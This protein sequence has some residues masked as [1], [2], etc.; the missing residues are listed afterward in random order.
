[1][2]GRKKK[3]KEG[4]KNPHSFEKKREEDRILRLIS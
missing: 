1:M 4:M 2:L 3:E